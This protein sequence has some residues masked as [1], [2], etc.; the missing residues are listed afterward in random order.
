MVISLTRSEIFTPDYPILIRKFAVNYVS[1][2]PG[3][4]AAQ[5]AHISGQSAHISVNRSHLRSIRSHL[6]SILARVREVC[7]RLAQEAHISG[8]SAHISDQIGRVPRRPLYISGPIRSHLRSILARVRE[9]C[10]VSAQEAHISGQS[11]H[12][13]DQSGRVAAQAAH[14]SGQSFHVSGPILSRLR[15]GRSRI[16]TAS[17][18][19]CTLPFNWCENRLSLR[20]FGQQYARR[21]V[22]APRKFSD[23]SS[24][25]WWKNWPSRDRKK[26]RALEGTA[27]AVRS[28]MRL[29]GRRE[30]NDRRDVKGIDR[31]CSGLARRR[32]SR[33]DR[34]M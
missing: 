18:S 4:V 27:G 21:A 1:D 20:W 14:I 25:L 5:A 34:K 10:Y 17:R 15:A 9:V 3:R 23:R 7:S 28:Q 31:R 6:R 2:Q 12:I 24:N 30:R 33:I 16:G 32:G 13:S 11:A 8:Q 29:H 19:I 26:S 22:C